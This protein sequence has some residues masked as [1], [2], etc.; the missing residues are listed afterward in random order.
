MNASINSI[1]KLN[2]PEFAMPQKSPRDLELSQ[3]DHSREFNPSANPH[4]LS[5]L[6]RELDQ[7]CPV[8][9]PLNEW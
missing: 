6:N 2:Y 4:I 5:W 3:P 7:P 1:T 8:Y 9:S